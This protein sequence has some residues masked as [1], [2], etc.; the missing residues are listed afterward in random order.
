MRD[1]NISQS[2]MSLLGRFIVLLYDRT[3]DLVKVNDT[4]KWL[5][6]QR[7]RSLENIP[8]AHAAL[9]QHIKCA[10]YQAYC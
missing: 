5:F 9:T 7:S 3:S 6:T 2:S 1:N 4:R 10:S 8:P